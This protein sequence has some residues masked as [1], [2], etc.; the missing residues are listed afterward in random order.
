MKIFPPFKSGLSVLPRKHYLS[1]PLILL[2]F[3]ILGCAP[4]KTANAFNND[5]EEILRAVQP[6]KKLGPDAQ[7]IYYNLKIS[8]SMLENNANMAY[9]LGL[10]LLKVDHSIPNI[11]RVS[12]LAANR[13]DFN[14]ALN[15]LQDALKEYPEQPSLTL[16]AVDAMVQTNK[17]AEAADLLEKYYH[18]RLEREKSGEKKPDEKNAPQTDTPE[19]PN[20][21]N[22]NLS[23][24]QLWLARLYYAADKNPQRALKFL[25][26]IPN[27]DS[28]LR[29]E[30]IK[31]LNADQKNSQVK[32]KFETLIKDMPKAPEVWVGFGE[33]EE[34]QKNYSKAAQYYFK[35]YQLEPAPELWLRG[36]AMLLAG[37]K[38][39]EAAKLTMRQQDAELVLRASTLFMDMQKWQT[40]EKILNSLSQKPN[41]P[42]EVNFFK[43][44]LAF[45]GRKDRAE[46]LRLLQLVPV[47]S[48]YHTRAMRM[49]GY[50][51]LDSGDMAAAKKAIDSF[52]AAYP[53]DIEA[54]QLQVKYLMA[55]KKP[56]E[57]ITLLKE[58]EK[59]QPDDTDLLYTLGNLLDF[60]GKK[61]EA[62]EY[63]EKIIAIDPA[64]AA[65]LNNAG[66]T[67]L[68][69]G[70]NYEKAL[71]Y[72]QR[73]LAA[74]PDV[75]HVL[76]SLAWAYYK[77]GRLEEAWRVI[78]Q[79]IAKDQT[80]AEI[81]EHYA[82]IARALNKNAEAAKGYRKAIELQPKNVRE[83][84]NKLKGL[85]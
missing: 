25:A 47:S 36:I 44:I 69:E 29:I 13:G 53:Q 77:L 8:N 21:L 71:E 59:N 48:P 68:E 54:I 65:A 4:Q 34:Q 1:L 58:A 31:L 64:N 57:A 17:T 43:A 41:T 83:L 63:M 67:M 40:A 74:E 35:A 85:E 24:I 51:L 61:Q 39:A 79:C 27:K 72:I 60:T 76:D 45:E 56:E 19:L 62:L 23:D 14:S 30:E 82:E 55:E 11:I 38:D 42:A 6:A 75:P 7:R 12:A 81:W 16:L 66:Y 46:A 20:A 22:T 26:S 37:G 84:E 52:R 32:K 9:A 33:F 70:Q 78:E 80:Q 49:T 15:I 50:L 5:Q 2:Y 10:E 18:R 73:S 3:V 28:D